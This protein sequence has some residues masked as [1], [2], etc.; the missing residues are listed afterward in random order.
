MVHF[1]ISHDPKKHKE[2]KIFE[3]NVNKNTAY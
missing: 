3:P 1:K 2:N